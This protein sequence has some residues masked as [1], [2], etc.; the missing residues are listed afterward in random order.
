VPVAELNG[1]SA[2]RSTGTPSV[3]CRKPERRRNGC[4]ASRPFGTAFV[5]QALRNLL[6]RSS[7]VISD[8]FELWLP[9]GPQ[10]PSKAIMQ[11]RNCS[12][13]RYQASL[14]SGIWTCPNAMHTLDA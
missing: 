10:R 6:E 3:P 7:T 12:I 2:T 4:W 5:Q 13:R 1:E 11:K 9:P 8:P 14:G